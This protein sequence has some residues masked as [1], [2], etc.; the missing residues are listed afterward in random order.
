LLTGRFC[1]A[2]TYAAAAHV[3][4][5]RKGTD[6]PYVSHL[7]AVAALV[8]EYGGSEPQATAAILHDVVEDCGGLERLADVREV[9]GEDVALLVARLSDSVT[10]AGVPKRPWRDRKGDYLSELERLVDAG[11]PAVLVSL[12]DKLHNARAIIADATDPDGPGRDV[13]DRFSAGPTEVA[14]YYGTLAELF[15]RAE[16]PARAIATYAA[17]VR[18]L[19]ALAERARRPTI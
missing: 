1:H 12:C 14:W 13:W 4:Q 8:L 11:D 2:V 18:D 9:F 17:V 5:V 10:G 19:A 7:L 16:L 6:I 15:E 3:G